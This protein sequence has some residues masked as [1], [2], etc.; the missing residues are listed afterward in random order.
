MRKAFVLLFLF[1]LICIAANAQQINSPSVLLDGHACVDLGLSVKW[2]TTNIGAQSPMGNGNYYAWGEIEPKTDYSKATSQTY[3]RKFND[4]SANPDYDVAAAEWGGHWRMPTSAEIK[5]LS[6]ECIFEQQTINGVT[7]CVVTGP[8]KNQIILP[9]AGWYWDNTKMEGGRYWASTPF[10]KNPKD[11]LGYFAYSLPLFGYVSTI[12]RN[13][14]YSVRPV[15]GQRKINPQP[16]NNFITAWKNKPSGI[17]DG[18]EYVDLGLSVKWAT[19][20]IG[21]ITPFDD[22]EYFSWAETTSN[23]YYNYKTCRR[24]GAWNDDISGNP[25]YD[26]VRYRWKGGWRMPTKAEC[27]ELTTKCTQSVIR[28]GKKS[29]LKYT[30]PN[31]NSIL[32]P[33]ADRMDDYERTFIGSGWYWTSTPSEYEDQSYYFVTNVSRG[34]VRANL[35]YYGMSVRGVIE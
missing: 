34:A 31:G 12:E 15:Y 1:S 19:C 4:I 10:E 9:I 32:L 22:G 20:N 13:M 17:K 27:E 24:N 3:N 21:A 11:T 33:E 8:N 16:K 14:G 2:A 26:V 28:I 29:Y 5:E 6:Q 23:D 18:H 25:V 30:G 7:V 35:R